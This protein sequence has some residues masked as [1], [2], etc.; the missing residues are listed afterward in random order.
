MRAACLGEAWV[1]QPRA[2]PMLRSTGAIASSFGALRGDK[3]RASQ[4]FTLALL[5]TNWKR[6]VTC[7]ARCEEFARAAALQVPARPRISSANNFA[8]ASAILT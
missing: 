4:E 3:H 5:A 7:N 8:D 1:D 2:K 6:D